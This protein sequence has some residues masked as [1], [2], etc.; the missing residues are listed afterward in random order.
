MKLVF[1]D[2]TLSPREGE[3]RLGAKIALSHGIAEPA[4]IS[5]LKKSLDARHKRRIVYR[6]K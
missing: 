1:D 2:I 4:V 5:I 6:Y 3:E